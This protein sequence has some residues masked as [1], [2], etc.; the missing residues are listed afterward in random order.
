VLADR[1]LAQMQ[2]GGGAQEAAIFSDRDEAAQG[3]HVQDPIH[4]HHRDD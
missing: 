2:D 1:S 4:A 3:R